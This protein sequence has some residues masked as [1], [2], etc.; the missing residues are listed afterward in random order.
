[1][2]VSNEFFIDLEPLQTSISY[3]RKLEEYGYCVSD[4]DMNTVGADNESGKM[5][6]AKMLT[7]TLGDELRLFSMNR[8]KV[9]SIGLKD[10]S[11]ILP[12]GHMANFAFWLD[13]ET[14]DFVSSSYYGLRLPKWAQKFNKK[15]LCEAYLSEKWELLLPSK[16]YDESLNETA[17][18]R[19]HLLDKNIQNFL[20]I[21]LSFSRK[22]ERV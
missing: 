9:I 19:N 8:S 2:L 3:D 11:A 17:L 22:M 7:T 14:G 6:P 18:M 12:G 5:S 15:D 16:A 10:R 1:M 4:T 13:S 21:Y 20:M